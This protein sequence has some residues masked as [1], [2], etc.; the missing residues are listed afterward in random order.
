MFQVSLYA[1]PHSSTPACPDEERSEQPSCEG[2]RENVVGQTGLEVYPR[3][4]VGDCQKPDCK[5]NG[6]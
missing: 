1:P 5:C 6:P 4:A 3:E 2:L